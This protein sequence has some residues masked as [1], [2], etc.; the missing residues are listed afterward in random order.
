VAPAPRGHRHNLNGI[1]VETHVW[2]L[3]DRAQDLAAP[4]HPGVA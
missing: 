1:G 4:A 3:R 2:S